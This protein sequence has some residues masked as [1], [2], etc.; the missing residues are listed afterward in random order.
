[1]SMKAECIKLRSP[2]AIY[3]HTTNQT[4][5]QRVPPIQATIGATCIIILCGA[6]I[7][8]CLYDKL[9]ILQEH[10]LNI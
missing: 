8:L 10:S 5:N 6:V 3:H 4:R 2:V 1:M 7:I 9:S